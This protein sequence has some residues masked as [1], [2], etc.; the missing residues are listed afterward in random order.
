MSLSNIKKL[1]SERGFT[2][3]ELL[4]V[5]VII[6]ILAAITI[7]AYNGIQNRAKASSSQATANSVQK[8][9]QTYYTLT[10]V[11]PS[12]TQLNTN[13]KPTDYTDSLT[14]AKLDDSSMI[15]NTPAGVSATTAKN[16]AT[17]TY[18]GCGTTGGKVGWWDYTKP[19]ASALTW[20]YLGDAT[21]ATTG[22]A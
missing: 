10:G 6:A 3:V 5:I 14:E 18:L 22:C 8:K 16:G 17:V 2:L 11:F 15:E 19:T 9:A 12:H 4:I 21:S 20:I 13:A 7:V 1:Q